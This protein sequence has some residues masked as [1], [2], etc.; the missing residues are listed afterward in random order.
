ME[1]Q[2][3]A[4]LQIDEISPSEGVFPDLAGLTAAN[5]RNSNYPSPRVPALLPYSGLPSP[6]RLSA[7][8]SAA[9]TS[10]CRCATR[11]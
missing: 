6:Q 1:L 11:G 10:T 9:S 2:T 4:P 7:A 5:T 3:R 8:R